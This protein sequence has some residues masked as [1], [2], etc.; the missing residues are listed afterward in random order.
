MKYK[1]LCQLVA[2][3]LNTK[4]VIREEGT[5]NAFITLPCRHVCVT[6]CMLIDVG[7]P[8]PLPVMPRLDWWWLNMSMKANQKP[9]SIV[10]PST[11]VWVI[12][13]KI[14]NDQLTRTGTCKP[15]KPFLFQV[16]FGHCFDHSNKRTIIKTKLGSWE[17]N[18]TLFKLFQN[19]IGETTY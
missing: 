11:P 13:M 16:A 3:E 9:S 10:L 12:A 6:F 18:K 2:C 8:S 14:L 4:I 7:W 19:R 15:D 5:G 17:R 1:S